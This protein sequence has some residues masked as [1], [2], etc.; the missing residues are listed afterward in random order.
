MIF[1]EYERRIKT[2]MVRRAITDEAK[3]LSQDTYNNYPELQEMEYYLRKH[4]KSNLASSI[5][6][7]LEAGNFEIK[8]R[9]N[10]WLFVRI[11]LIHTSKNWLTFFFITNWNSFIEEHNLKPITFDWNFVANT[12]KDPEIEIPE[13]RVLAPFFLP[14]QTNNLIKFRKSQLSNFNIM[15]S[16]FQLSYWVPIS[17]DFIKW[18]TTV[19]NYNK[20]IIENTP[21][22]VVNC[23]HPLQIKYHKYFVNNYNTKLKRNQRKKSKFVYRPPIVQKEKVTIPKIIQDQCF[24][25]SLIKKYIQS[26]NIIPQ[27]QITFDPNIHPI[28]SLSIHKPSM[29]TSK[30]ALLNLVHYQYILWKTFSIKFIKVRIKNNTPDFNHILRIKY[31][32]YFVSNYY[33]RLRRNQERVSKFTYKSAPIQ[34]DKVIIPEQI[35]LQ[36]TQMSKIKS[37]VKSFNRSQNLLKYEPFANLKALREN[38][39]FVIR[40]N[41]IS[42]EEIVNAAYKQYNF[43]S[44]LAIEEIKGIIKDNTPNQNQIILPKDALSIKESYQEFCMFN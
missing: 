31:Y 43:W 17:S 21:K 2:P 44:N 18:R 24:Q 22:Y 6:K 42:N 36:C 25:I 13:Y 41:Y 4:C 34:K 10:S 28:S 26:L 40:E 12:Y 14:S 30:E 1:P 7:R 20:F 23:E 27:L 3:W 29:F 16:L 37:F 39:L 11:Y 9:I 19:N 8:A 32:P 38:I 15:I 33:S 35:Q 5:K